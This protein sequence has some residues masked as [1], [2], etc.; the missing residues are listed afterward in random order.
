MC[1]CFMW[2]HRVLVQPGKERKT[3]MEGRCH[4]SRPVTVW[5]FDPPEKLCSQ[6]WEMLL[7]KNMLREFG[8]VWA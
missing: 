4:K 1:V 2:T 5:E 3:L 8:M 7:T 6:E